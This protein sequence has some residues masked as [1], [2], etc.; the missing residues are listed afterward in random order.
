MLCLLDGKVVEEDVLT[1]RER[2]RATYIYIYIKRDKEQRA[3]FE[4]NNK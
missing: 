3:W 4:K 1:Q 2:E